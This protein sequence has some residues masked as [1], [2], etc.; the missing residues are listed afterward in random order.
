MD[1]VALA[2]GDTF[3]EPSDQITPT[4]MDFTN[5]GSKVGVVF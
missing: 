5:D 3:T 4:M 2:C 1:A